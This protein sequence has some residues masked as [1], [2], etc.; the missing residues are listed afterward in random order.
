V[1]SALVDP[2][3][4]D[5]TAE[6][7]ARRRPPDP[8]IPKGLNWLLTTIDSDFPNLNER[9]ER[10]LAAR[11]IANAKQAVRLDCVFFF[12]RVYVYVMVSRS[13]SLFVCAF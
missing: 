11:K 10:D 8:A 12:S 9:V 5:E 7:K 6:E 3:K 2:E 13:N 1:I 4:E